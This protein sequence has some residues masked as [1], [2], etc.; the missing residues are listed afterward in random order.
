V[1]MALAGGRPVTGSLLPEPG[2]GGS[3]AAVVQMV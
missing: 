1:T 3:K 2:W